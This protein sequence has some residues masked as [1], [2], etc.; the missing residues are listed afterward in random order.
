MPGNIVRV[1]ARAVVRDAEQQ[2][3]RGK[4]SGLREVERGSA[5]EAQ[6]KYM[7]RCECETGIAPGW[8]WLLVRPAGCRRLAAAF[9]GVRSWSPARAKFLV[10]AWV[11]RR[12]FV[13]C[14]LVKPSL[15]NSTTER[16]T[17]KS[18]FFCII[19]GK[20]GYTHSLSPSRPP[21]N[22]LNTQSRAQQTHSRS[23]S[24]RAHSH[25]AD[26]P[27]ASCPAPPV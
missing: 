1:A 24:L 11:T 10:V 9:S 12:R 7:E 21:N 27:P 18:T 14:N 17:A 23:P 3:P 2:V 5:A 8:A 22:T 26:L 20:T 6:L 4:A 19:R 13:L 15:N 16:S 25:R